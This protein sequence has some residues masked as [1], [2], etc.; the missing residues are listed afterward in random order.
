MDIENY[1]QIYN[2][3]NKQQIPTELNSKEKQRFINR[4]K[5]YKIKNEQLYK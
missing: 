5:N 4:T 2:Y 1:N 3:L